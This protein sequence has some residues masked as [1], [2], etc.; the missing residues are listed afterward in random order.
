MPATSAPL[1]EPGPTLLAGHVAVEESLDDLA[2]STYEDSRRKLGKEGQ[3]APSRSVGLELL[4]MID[5]EPKR[6]C[7]RH[8]GVD[9]AG[10]RAR[11]DAFD[12]VTG[13]RLRQALRDC[14]PVSIED[15]CAIERGG[16]KPLTRTGMS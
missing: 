11:D 13:K 14:A 7:Q 6:T 4:S 5:L 9:A 15:S 10:V 8:H 12:D 3:R 1:Q 16:G 2:V